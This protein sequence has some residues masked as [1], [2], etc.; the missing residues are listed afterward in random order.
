MREIK[1]RAWYIEKGEM[2]YNPDLEFCNFAKGYGVR[3]LRH[4]M[5]GFAI[6]VGVNRY[7]NGE[8]QE[9][10]EFI[11]EQYTGLKDK[12][13]TEIYE[14]DIENIDGELYIIEWEDVGFHASPIAET[15]VSM[16]GDLNTS[17][18]WFRVKADFGEVIGNI[19]ENKEFVK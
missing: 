9:P 1:F 11:I 8:Q 16:C 18:S 3:L 6:P 19:H 14:G 7:V 10:D 5:E 4:Y 15:W 17:H 13:G 12:N 2:I